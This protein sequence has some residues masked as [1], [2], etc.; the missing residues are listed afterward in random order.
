MLPTC[1]H[2]KTG[3]TYGETL[4]NLLLLRCPHC[5]EKNFARKFRPRDI[6]F[7]I[8]SSIIILFLFPFFD[9]SF[10]WTVLF[11]V[12]AIGV[13]IATYPINLELTKEEEPLF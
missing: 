13:Y 8:A 6:I 12:I 9:V 5:G 4:K 11:A 10:V 7:G 1:Q 3:W 2:C